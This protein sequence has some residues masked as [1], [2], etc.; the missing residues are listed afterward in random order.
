MDDIPEALWHV[1]DA[2]IRHLA[3]RGSSLAI[4][5]G[6]VPAWGL[7]DAFDRLAD[8]IRQ[9]MCAHGVLAI[10]GDGLFAGLARVRGDRFHSVAFQATIKR[11]QIRIEAAAEL[12][13]LQ[14]THDRLTEAVAAGHLG[15]DLSASLGMQQVLD[16]TP[17]DGTE[18]R[19]TDDPDLLPRL[20]FPR[21]GGLTEALLARSPPLYKNAIVELMRR[22]EPAWAPGR[23]LGSRLQGAAESLVGLKKRG[24]YWQGLWGPS[25]LPFGSR[26]EKEPSP[27]CGSGGRRALSDQQLRR[28]RGRVGVAWVVFLKAA[29]F[30]ACWW[31][32]QEGVCSPEGTGIGAR[33][34]GEPG[35]APCA[36]SRARALASLGGA[37]GPGSR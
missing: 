36:R 18:L 19:N 6:K 28:F 20:A 15:A 25:D 34:G 33:L 29:G 27:A 13:T 3:A 32:V 17:A 14:Y 9:R 35:G 21:Q 5:G 23:G 37:Q 10:A 7:P 26:P 1:V 2:I 24:G 31:T 4:V 8:Q 30:K 16:F 12:V 11:L 22:G